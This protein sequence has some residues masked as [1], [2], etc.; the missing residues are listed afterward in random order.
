MEGVDQ[1]SIQLEQR[2]PAGA[3]D[4]AGRSPLAAP[5]LGDV[6]R[7]C[8]CVF[9][10]AAAR[11]VDAHEISVTEAAN[12]ALDVL[13]TARPEVAAGE[14]AEDSWSTGIRPFALE[15]VEDLLD[16]VAHGLAAMAPRSLALLARPGTLIV[17]VV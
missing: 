11:P 15:R 6:A 3:D 13:G 9:E 17:R 16:Q 2:L 8:G 10:A 7:E 5:R 1:P 12:R 4:E 14:P